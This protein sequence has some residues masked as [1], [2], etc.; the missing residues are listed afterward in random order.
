MIVT[1]AFG[2]IPRRG[3]G[4]HT[5][6]PTDNG[7]ECMEISSLMNQNQLRRMCRLVVLGGR[8]TTAMLVIGYLTIPECYRI[9]RACFADA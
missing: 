2:R 7:G 1:A 4:I 5:K 9:T 6:C 3:G 8:T